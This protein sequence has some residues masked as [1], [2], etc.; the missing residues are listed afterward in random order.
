MTNKDLNKFINILNRKKV[1][2]KK[3]K[4]QIK[5][6]INKENVFWGTIF[7]EKKSPFCKDNYYFIKNKNKFVG[8]IQDRGNDLHW[9][10]KKEYRGQGIMTTALKN[11]ILPHILKNKKEQIITTDS[12]EEQCLFEKSNNLALKIGFKKISEEIKYPDKPWSSKIYTYKITQK[13]LK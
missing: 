8:I 7:Y 5:E 11:Y 12:R 3:V 10:L 6:T 2:D 1:Y 4:I 9:Y 13:D